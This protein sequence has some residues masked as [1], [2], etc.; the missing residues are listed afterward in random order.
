M[1]V[2]DKITKLSPAAE[3]KRL[4]A[5]VDKQAEQLENLRAAKFKIPAG[6]K[7]A[8]KGKTFSRVVIPDSHGAHLDKVA[9]KA[10]L[11]D[12]ESLRPSEVVML[13]DHLDCAGFL[14]QHHTLGFVP[15]TAYTFE[16]DVAACNAFLDEIQKRVGNVPIYYIVGNHEHRIEKYIL[17][18]TVNNPAD[19]AYLNKM[20]G[21]DSVLGLSKR[22]IE[23]I[24]RGKQYH[25]LRKRGTIRLGSCLFTHGVRT[26][27]HAARQTLLDVGS[28]VVFGHIHQITTATKETLDSVIA[29]HCVGCLCELNPTYSD[30]RTTNWAH[31]Y[32]LQVVDSQSKKF[33]HVTVPI[34]DGYSMLHNLIA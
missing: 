12:L 29:A 11:D 10:F 7:K 21:L 22:G 14:A 34:I 1:S 23:M 8:K 13:G 19:S 15:E 28:N 2:A 17:K 30:T 18:M 20:F 3:I 4:Q 27:V 9:A 6:G 32:G 5:L 25:G 24:E 33:L 16:D 31:G 26:G